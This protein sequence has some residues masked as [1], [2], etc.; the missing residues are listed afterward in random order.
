[1][2]RSVRELAAIEMVS[3]GGA[4]EGLIL[5]K[6]DFLLI[7]GKSLMLTVFSSLEKLKS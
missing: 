7:F 5:R 6:V 1:M 2:A 4:K 3:G